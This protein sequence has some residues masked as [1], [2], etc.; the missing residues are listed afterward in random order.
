MSFIV[1]IK[2]F[3]LFRM[4]IILYILHKLTLHEVDNFKIYMINKI[5]T[6]KKYINN[7]N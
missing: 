3:Q 4:K 7:S 2:F 1:M 6:P 5:K